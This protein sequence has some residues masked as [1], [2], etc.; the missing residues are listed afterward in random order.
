MNRPTVRVLLV[1]DDKDVYT[2]V[3]KYLKKASS[4]PFEVQWAA[5]FEEALGAIGGTEHDVCLLDYRL[6]ERTGIELL[7]QVRASGRELPVIILTGLGSFELDLEV[8]E[9]GAFDYLEKAELTP[10]LLER[11]IRY[12]IENHRVRAA[13]RKANE[14][15]DLRVRERTAELDRSNRDLE[16]FANVVAHDLQAPLQALTRQIRQ[17]KLHEP[18]RDE[19]QVPDLAS[20]YLDPVLHAVKN[21]ELMVRCVLDCSQVRRETRPFEMVDL[22]DIVKEACSELTNIITDTHATIEV[23]T[24]PS[25]RG[26]R[27]CLVGLFENLLS[28]AVKFRGKDPPKIRI[29]AERKGDSWL[30]AVSDNGIGVK[31]E[32]ADDIFMMFNRGAV[33]AQYPGIGIGLAMCRKIMQSYGGKI[34]VDSKPDG[35]STFYF[36]FPAE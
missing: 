7:R 12:T 31:D 13:L 26:D 15:L 24:M 2:L 21:M 30:C 1:D 4:G 9:M 29:W 28:N 23:G 36:T 19:E 11:S 32:D 8:M 25:V 6:G 27:P 16:Q 34:W 20:R 5:S 10:A 18:G 17:M 14:E 3:R 22:S 35:G 33:K